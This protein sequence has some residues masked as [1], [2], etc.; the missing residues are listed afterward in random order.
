MLHVRPFDRIDL[1]SVNA[2]AVRMTVEEAPHVCEN[3]R[4][5]TSAR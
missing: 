4:P 5:E 2:L 3:T 1:R